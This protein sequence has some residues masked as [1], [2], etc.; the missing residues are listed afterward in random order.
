MSAVVQLLP[1][2]AIVAVFWF[3]LMRPARNRQRATAQ[4]QSQIAVGDEVM[5]SAGIFGTVRSL[6]DKQ[7][8][9][10]IAPGTT[11]KVVRAAVLEQVGP[12]PA[13]DAQTQGS[14]DVAADERGEEGE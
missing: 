2:I 14:D 13:D 8:D 7:V 5:I 1:V 11:I 4:L 12:P 3:L 6:D 9:L 10:E